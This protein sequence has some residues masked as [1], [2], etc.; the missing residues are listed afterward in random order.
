MINDIV[1]RLKIVSSSAEGVAT[2]VLLDGVPL[3]NAVSIHINKVNPGELTTATI[4]VG[5]IAF[6]VYIE[7]ELSLNL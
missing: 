7:V 5:E 3:S 1:R 6:E 4:K 2:Q